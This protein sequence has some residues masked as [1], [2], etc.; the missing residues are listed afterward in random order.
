MDN[1]KGK[2][3]LKQATLLF[4]IMFCA[5]GIR[6]ISSYTASIAK[7]SCWLVPFC[8]VIFYIIFAVIIY[9]IYKNYYKESF[10]QIIQDIFG[11]LIGN[12]VVFLFFC[13]ITIDLIYNIRIFGER[14]LG[15]A[16]P[17]IDIVVLIGIL[18]MLVFYILKNGFVPLAR[19]NELFSI[20]IF[21][22]LIV[23]TVLLIPKF[24]IN[25]LFPVT[26]KDALPILNANIGPVAVFSYITVLFMLSDKIVNRQKFKKISI[27]LITT[28][29]L[30]TLIVILDP[31][32][33]FGWSLVDKMPVP[34]INSVME[35]S[36][37]E[38]LE[39]VESLIIMFWILTDFI[40]IS[41]LTYSAI[42]VIG[43]SLKISKTNSILSIYMIFLLFMSLCIAKSNLELE[44]ISKSLI[45]PLNIIM[46][47]TVPVILFTV[48]KIRKK[49]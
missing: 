22:I 4:I 49:I 27:V 46:G 13:W 5:P 40:M 18:L 28:L 20:F 23:T 29:T 2:I 34:F 7:Q 12:I 15:S 21:A 17:N 33:I 8:S 37:F 3:S 24:E 31:L 9:K 14:L 38:T 10:V 47:Y 16:M 48:G 39:R 19:M 1:D 30:I 42:H 36:F 25:N 43:V 26:Y 44:A 41:I 6:F 11:K 45:V 35:I 32:C